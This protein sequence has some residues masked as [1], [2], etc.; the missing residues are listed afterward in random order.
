MILPPD[1]G[2]SEH[3]TLSIDDSRRHL[4]EQSSL[5]RFLTRYIFQCF[6]FTQRA[7]LILIFLHIT[8]HFLG[9][10]SMLSVEVPSQSLC[11]EK[12]H[13][14]PSRVQSIDT[15]AQDPFFLLALIGVSSTHCRV[16]IEPSLALHRSSPSRSRSIGPSGSLTLS[17][18]PVIE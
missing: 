6:P 3:T 13:R 18:L 11:E 1:T 5:I 15:R 7:E 17:L 16:K 2:S 12:T 8:N 9:G 14:N 4:L 10:L